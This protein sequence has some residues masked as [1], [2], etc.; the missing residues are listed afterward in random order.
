MKTSL[1]KIVLDAIESELDDSEY[2]NGLDNSGWYNWNDKEKFQWCYNVWFSSASPN[3]TS[4][5]TTLDEWLAGL[6][7]PIPCMNDNIRDMGH[8]PDTFFLDCACEIVNQA[9][10]EHVEYKNIQHPELSRQPLKNYVRRMVIEPTEQDPPDTLEGE[11]I[12]GFH[13]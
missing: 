12:T 7:I 3:T 2:C 8:D 5:K 13:D 11:F 9:G 1:T 6:P 4:M 10:W